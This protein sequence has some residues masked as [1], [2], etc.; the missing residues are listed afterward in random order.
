MYIVS[1]EGSNKT[2]TPPKNNVLDFVTI[3]GY[4]PHVKVQV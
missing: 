2:K 4:N 3:I 1:K